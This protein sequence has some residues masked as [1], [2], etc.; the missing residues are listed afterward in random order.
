VA[1]VFVGRVL[2]I[3]PHLKLLI[4]I[5]TAICGASAIAAV[6]PIIRAKHQEIAYAVAV[7][8]TFNVA[9]I[10]LFPS[11]GHM[12]NL[13]AETFGVWAGTAVNDTSSV[14]ATA[15]AFGETSSEHAV[16]VKLARTTAIVPLVILLAL[17]VRRSGPTDASRAFPLF[18]VWFLVGATL[19]T[20]GV[21]PQWA[22]A[23]MRP[24]ADVAIVIALAAVGLTTSVGDV[25][26]SGFRPLLFGAS[27]WAAVALTSLGVQR[28]L[29]QW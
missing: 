2:D 12:L 25:R 6:A 16:V 15:F 14:I 13:S 18:I 20:A 17:I 26:S 11:V 27:V 1:A 28:A 29:G 10:A 22:E 19:N 9:A 24:S 5:G 21:I 4:G 3:P 23:V 7:I 8:F